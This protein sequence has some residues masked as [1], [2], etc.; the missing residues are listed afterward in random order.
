MAY[1]FIGINTAILGGR[2]GGSVGIGFAIPA[3]M[4]LSLTSQI[5][6][7]GEVRR[8]QLGVIVQDLTLEL[9]NALGIEFVSGALISQVLPNSAAQEAG[10]EEGDVVISVNGR[11]TNGASSLR[12]VIGLARAGEVVEIQ[13][14][15]DGETFLRKVKIRSI[16]T[17]VSLKERTDGFLAGVT[18]G[19]PSETNAGVVVLRVE[20]ETKAWSAGLRPQDLILSINRI[21]INKLE[22]VEKAIALNASGILLNIRRGNYAL[23]IV[24]R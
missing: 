24:I 20:R 14:L 4:A 15:R 5:V 2:G 23:F 1:T 8:G 16:Q 10:L 19:E 6:E 17:E 21:K 9:A 22:D 18:L 12:N 7:Y 13:Y 3:N 11:S